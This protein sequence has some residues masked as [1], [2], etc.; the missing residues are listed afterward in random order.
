MKSYILL[1]FS[2]IVA[3]FISLAFLFNPAVTAIIILGIGVLL[4]LIKDIEKTIVVLCALFPFNN[5]IIFRVGALDIRLIELAWCFVLPYLFATEVVLQKKIV[6][7]RFKKY[8]LFF[9]GFLLIGF[10]RTIFYSNEYNLIIYKEII[11]AIYLFSLFF[12]ARAVFQKRENLYLFLKIIVWVTLIFCLF[13][14]IQL[15]AG[16]FPFRSIYLSPFGGGVYIMPPLSGTQLTEHGGLLLRRIESFFWGEVGTAN[17]LIIMYF[18]I[19]LVEFKWRVL[20]K[21]LIV[22]LLLLTGSRAGWI[23]LYILIIADLIIRKKKFL[24]KFISSFTIVFFLFYLIPPLRERIMEIFSASESSNRAHLA[25]WLTGWDMFKGH[26]ILGVGMGCFAEIAKISDYFRIFD[27]YGTRA[28]HNFLLRVLAETGILGLIFLVSFF[29][30]FS[31]PMKRYF[32]FRY[33]IF[34]RIAFAFLGTVLMNM[35]MNAFWIEP[36]W[37]V[38]ALLV[39]V[40]TAIEK[41]R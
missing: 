31:L 22:G 5:I 20:L 11:K 30:S 19:S 1:L 10:V 41:K 2:I 29:A 17:L 6:D 33:P 37:I 24:L 9:L 38:F 32:N 7:T 27:I 13:G 23:I 35:T 16:T 26:F 15:L 28:A 12:V 8:D 34:V 14:Y 39:G 40:H 3:F 18:L 4:I 36:F 25:I 21:I